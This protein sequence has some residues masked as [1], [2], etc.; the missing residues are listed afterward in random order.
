MG[1][2]GKG[3]LIQAKLQFGASNPTERLDDV[4][5][6]SSGQVVQLWSQSEEI[7]ASAFAS[8]SASASAGVGSTTEGSSPIS[9]FLCANQPAK[10]KFPKTMKYNAV[11][12]FRADWFRVHPWL[13]YPSTKEDKAYC[14]VCCK[15]RDLGLAFPVHVQSNFTVKGFNDWTN[16]TRSFDEHET[17]K[18]HK[19]AIMFLQKKTEIPQMVMPVLLE[20]QNENKASLVLM[21]ETLVHLAKLGDPIRGHDNDQG[22]YMSLLCLR[23]NDRPEL[24]RFLQRGRY[25]SPEITKELLKWLMKATIDRVLVQI[26]NAP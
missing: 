1:D 15:A 4:S 20:Q 9:G 19:D 21:L 12:S 7:S 26:R 2:K 16:A 8:A 25:L 18:Q 10:V 17:S 23:S 5:S 6:S 24:A 14:F 13:H 22:H 11:R 3:K